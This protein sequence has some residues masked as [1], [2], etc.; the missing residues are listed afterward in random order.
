MGQ[1]IPRGRMT[2]TVST[3]AEGWKRVTLSESMPVP[4]AMRAW[5]PDACPHGIRADDAIEVVV[6]EVMVS[7][8]QNREHRG[9]AE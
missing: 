2:E 4:Q 3:S 8:R 7:M 6:S 5:V 1:P 9:A